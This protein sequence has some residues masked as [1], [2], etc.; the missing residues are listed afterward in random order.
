MATTKV[1]TLADKTPVYYA[2]GRR[3]TSVARVFMKSGS[4]KIVINGIEG[5]KYFPNKYLILDA[6]RPL[7]LTGTE[8]RF[9]LNI[10]VKGGGY[11]SQEGAVRLGIARA[12]LLVSSDFRK[13]L[14][15][16]GLITVDSRVVERKKY[17]LHKARKAP[18]FSKR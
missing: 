10:T 8:G 17:G 4:G 5:E 13:V 7:D 12:L 11:S 3:K 6:K 1:I 16:N 14:K 9:D 18:Q 15:S 2:T